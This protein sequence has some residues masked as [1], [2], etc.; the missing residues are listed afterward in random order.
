MKSLNDFGAD[1]W[2]AF[3]VFEYYP[4]DDA[5]EPGRWWLV[6]LKRRKSAETKSEPGALG[7][8]VRSEGWRAPTGPGRGVNPGPV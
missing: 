8:A 6:L 4:P 2:E 7:Y 5:K 1:G 3:N